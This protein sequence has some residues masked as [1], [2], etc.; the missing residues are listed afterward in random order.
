M[1]AQYFWKCLKALFTEHLPHHEEEQGK[2]DSKLRQKLLTTSAAQLDR[3]L[4]ARKVRVSHR[5]RFGTKP[6]GL[7]KT[8]MPIRTDN[9]D[10]TRPVGFTRSRPY[11]T[12]DN[13]HV[14]QKNWTHVRRLLGYERIYDPALVEAIITPAT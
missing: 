3:L 10:I 4:A 2:L 8:K 1:S 12:N 7:L 6:K 13:S 5:G 14:D 11:K 9:W